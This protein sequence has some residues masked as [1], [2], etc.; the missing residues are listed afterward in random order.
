MPFPCVRA[1]AA[2]Q[3]PPKRHH[4]AAPGYAQGAGPHGP[5]QH[6]G[7]PSHGGNPMQAPGGHPQHYV[8]SYV[9]QPAPRG[10]PPPTMY[11]G[12]F[13][14]GGAGPAAA[15]TSVYGH[16]AAPPMP[17]GR[18]GGFACY[19]AAGRLAVACC[20]AYSCTIPCTVYHLVGRCRALEIG[21]TT[22]VGC[23]PR[24]TCPRCCMSCSAARCAV[25]CSRCQ[26]HAPVA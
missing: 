18:Q 2:Q 3:Q 4:P 5:S 20:L 6:P 25:F 22:R 26:P 15:T 1:A 10:P 14:G 21:S 23:M 24:G 17:G 19:L 11:P 9:Q 7:H 12:S 8:Q 16:G 13:G